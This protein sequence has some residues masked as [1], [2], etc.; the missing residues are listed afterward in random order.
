MSGL[1]CRWRQKQLDRKRRGKKADNPNSKPPVLGTL[2]PT[3]LGATSEAYGDALAD[4]ICSSQGGSL[5]LS[6]GKKVSPKPSLLLAAGCWANPLYA[7]GNFAQFD[8]RN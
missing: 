2:F 3:T 7:D 4:F 6:K 5:K 1:S 8:N